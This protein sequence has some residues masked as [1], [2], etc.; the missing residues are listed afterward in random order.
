[1]DENDAGADANSSTRI[2]PANFVIMLEK[3]E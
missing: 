2:I 3:E 1:M